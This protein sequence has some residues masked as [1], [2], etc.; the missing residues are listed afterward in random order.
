MAY[1]SDQVSELRS[2]IQ[3]LR[4]LADDLDSLL[5]GDVKI[6]PLVRITGWAVAQRAVPCLLGKMHNHPKVG[7]FGFTTELYFLDQ[8]MGLART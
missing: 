4:S 2:T 6:D 3:K 1:S 7:D 5:G 8:R